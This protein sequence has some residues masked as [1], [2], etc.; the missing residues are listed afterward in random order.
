MK[1]QKT[2]SEV[3]QLWAVFLVNIINKKNNA[4]PSWHAALPSN[5]KSLIGRFWEYTL[6]PLQFAWLASRHS[7]ASAAEQTSNKWNTLK[8]SYLIGFLLE[9]VILLLFSPVNFWHGFNG[10]FF[11]WMCLHRTELL[12][13]VLHDRNRLSGVLSLV[14]LIWLFWPYPEFYLHYL[15]HDTHKRIIRLKFYIFNT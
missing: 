12:K 4:E 15:I 9:L 7:S 5:I 8:P 6:S 10:G 3:A 1:V 14:A 13:L 2:A 11:S